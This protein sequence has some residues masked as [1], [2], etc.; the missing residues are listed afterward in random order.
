ME[1]RIESFLKSENIVPIHGEA[2]FDHIGPFAFKHMKKKVPVLVG[3]GTSSISSG[4]KLFVAKESSLLKKRKL[5]NLA[6]K[7]ELDIKSG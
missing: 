3:F 5:N 7:F 2:I 4:S 1:A 6:G